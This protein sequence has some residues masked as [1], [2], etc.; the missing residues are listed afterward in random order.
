MFDDDESYAPR[1]VVPDYE[2][3]ASGEAQFV[4]FG[5]AAS[6]EGS[7]KDESGILNGTV[8]PF[9]NGY[10]TQEMMDMRT[11]GRLLSAT[12]EQSNSPPPYA[13]MMEYT[14]SD[15]ITTASSQRSLDKQPNNFTHPELSSSTASV[16]SKETEL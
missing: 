8:S 11:G 1:I 10:G 5:R 4:S 12:T 9:A 6:C 3:E 13:V 7:I 15:I 16:K 14:D 2:Y